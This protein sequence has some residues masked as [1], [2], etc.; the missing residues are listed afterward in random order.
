[1]T[2]D[3]FVRLVGGKLVHAT[4]RDNLPGIEAR[5]LL[6]P[7]TLAAL[8][9]VDPKSLVLREQ[10]TVLDLG[11]HRAHLNHQKPLRAGRKHEGEFLDGHTLESW[12]EQMNRRIFLWPRRKGIDFLKSL[13]DRGAPMSLWLDAGRVFDRMA[14]HLDLAPISTGDATRRPAKRGDWIYVPVSLGVEDFRQNR[15]RRGLATTADTV[16]EVSIRADVP[17]EL[18]AEMRSP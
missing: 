9:G 12:S 5:G 10:D 2:R 15:V 16:Q 13:F 3:E 14:E 7:V 4:L 8:A 17:P 1:M 18:L 6:R 11:K